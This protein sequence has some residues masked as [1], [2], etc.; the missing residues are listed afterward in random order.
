[1]N[2]GAFEY[3]LITVGLESAISEARRMGFMENRELA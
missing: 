3:T 1:M 2:V